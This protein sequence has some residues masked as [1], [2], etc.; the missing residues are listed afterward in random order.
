MIE[1]KN[2]SRRFGSLQAV[3]NVTL[4]IRSNKI[5]GLFGR[6]GAGKTTLLNMVTNRMFPNNGL[7]RVGGLP[8]M[9]N[10]NALSMISM[11]GE[12]DMYEPSVRVLT[13]MEYTKLFYPA[14]DIAYAKGLAERFGLDIRRKTG[15]LSTG[16]RSIFKLILTLASGAPYLIFDEPVLGLDANHRQLFYT[17]LLKR[18][19]QTECTVVLSTHLIEEI[20]GMIEHVVIMDKGKILVDEEAEKV[21]AMGFTVSGREEEV[22]AF[23][24]GYKVIGT[25]HLGGLMLAHILG[26][27]SGVPQNLEVV[28]LDLQQM[29]IHL[30]DS[31]EGGLS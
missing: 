16:Y 4:N 31:E 7:I 22:R 17:E 20:S 5:V 8:V 15:K 14:F 2:V 19:E 13:A 10:D 28:P 6:N 1:L 11:M 12:Q 3:D 18:Y 9:E 26:E 27:V 23:C 30:T 25:Q 24:T 21:R 29:F